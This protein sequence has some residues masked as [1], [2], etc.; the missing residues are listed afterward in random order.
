MSKGFPDQIMRERRARL[1]AERLLEHARME[2]TAANDRLKAHAFNL[3]DQIIE[4]RAELQGMR[5]IAEQLEG[6][7]TQTS[8]ELQIA[9]SVANLADLRLREAV[10]TITDGFAV[11]DSDQKLVL[12]NQAYL[13]VFDGFP[14]VTQGIGYNRILEICAYEGLVDLQGTAPGDWVQAMLDRWSKPQITPLAM[15]FLNGVS[16]RLMDRRVPNG[17][18]VSLVRNITRSLKYQAQ[19]IEAQT[20]AEAAAQTKSAFLANMSHEIRTPMNGVVG[21]ADLLAETKLDSE[22]RIYAET[23]RN[24][25]QALVTIINDILDFSKMDAGK[26]DLYP[27]DFDLEKTIHEVLTLLAPAARGKSIELI[28][29]YD[30][31]L[32]RH[33]KADPGRVRQVLT[34][35]IGNAVKFTETGYVL[36]RAV[37]VN[38][39]DEGQLVHITVEDTGIGIAPEHSEHVFSEFQ[40]VEDA[41]NRRF[42]GT[43][44]G[45]AISKRIIELMGGSIWLESEPGIGSCFGCSLNLEIATT[46]DAN[47]SFPPPLPQ[48]LQQVLLISD[49]LISRGILERHFQSARVRTLTATQA[50]PAL[51]LLG[52]QTVDLVLID[53]DLSSDDAAQIA[54]MIEKEAPGC[55]SIMMCSAMAEHSNLATTGVIRHAL[56]KPL[57]WRDVALSICAALAETQTPMPTPT[58]AAQPDGPV[59]TDHAPL[60]VL[61]AEDNATNRLVFSKMVQGL[62]LELHFAVNG[63]EAVEKFVEI[64]PDIIFMDVSM[65]EMDGREATQHIRA[66]GNGKTVPIIAL[67]AHALQEETAKM[68]SAGMNATLAKPL[69]KAELI[70][71]LS[72]H[73]PALRPVQT[74]RTNTG[75]SCAESAGSNS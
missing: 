22:Q 29:D 41:T 62:D 63:R 39:S 5:S 15:H 32:P 55:P 8:Q 40:Q 9:H 37:G 2:L 47:H 26:M 6:V 50:I 67:T 45:L 16:V 65:P 68:L 24:S 53:Q 60:K 51:R 36:V 70:D 46:A 44:L 13:S 73:R 66:F 31:F 30:I 4:Q 11:F 48:R 19:L 33:F 61:Y 27:E 64:A 7:N 21:M 42:E 12:A 35:L 69:R 57:L 17:D 56:P 74:D 72:R 38:K 10:E 54:R 1:R 14:E 25:G 58:A 3:S 59:H 18:Y 52:Q 49:H 43:G 20:Q 75:L 23:I 28:L 34:N 71:A